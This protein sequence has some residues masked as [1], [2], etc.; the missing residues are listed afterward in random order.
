MEAAW[1]TSPRW[2][3]SGSCF[4]RTVASGKERRLTHEPNDDIQPAWSPDGKRLAF[5]RARTSG[6]KLEPNDINGWYQDGG[7]IWTI[8]IATGRETKLVDDAFNPAYSPTGG[9]LAFDAAWAGARRIWIADSTGRNPRQITSDSSEAVVHTGPRWSPDG[10]RLAFRRVEKIKS[11]IAAV[12]LASQT[13]TRVTNDNIPDMD[14]VWAPDGRH[15]Y[16]ASSRGGGMNLWRIGVAYRRRADRPAR[17]AHHRRGR[18]HR[19]DGG[20]GRQQAGVRGAGHQL[21]S[22]ALAGGSHDR[23]TGRPTRARGEHHPGRE[24]GRVVARWPHHRVQ[25]RPVGRD[26]HLAA[27]RRGQHRAAAHPGRREATTSQTG[28]PTARAS[29]SSPPAPAPRTSG[30][31]GPATAA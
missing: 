9:R 24:P 13:L 23:S 26:E 18:R 5:V 27:Q 11:D 12:D 14:P 28:R 6:G 21:G 25:L 7:D 17:A 16:F 2:T 29:P 22:L 3:A 1:P 10:S 20:A 4:V 15:L 30:P 31:C 8:D 19:A